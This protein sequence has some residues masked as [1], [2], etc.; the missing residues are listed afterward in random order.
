MSSKLELRASLLT[1][2]LALSPSQVQAESQRLCDA[3]HS[4]DAVKQAKRLVSYCATNNEIDPSAFVNACIEKGMPV[5]IPKC[6][7][8]QYKLVLIDADTKWQRGAFQILEPEENGP[9]LDESARTDAATAWLVPGLGFSA[10]KQRIGY[11]KGIY[12]HLLAQTAGFKLGLAYRFQSGLNFEPEAH[13]I[14]M[15]AVLL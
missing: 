15:S 13:D 6:I 14:A 3:L 2:R 1:Q 10:D 9:L 4:L 7:N 12:D 5:Y 8:G 11:G